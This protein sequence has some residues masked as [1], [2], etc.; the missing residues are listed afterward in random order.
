MSCSRGKIMAIRIGNVCIEGVNEEDDLKKH[1]IY[2]MGT[3]LDEVITKKQS[4][5]YEF[6]VIDGSK[7]CLFIKAIQC[8]FNDKWPEDP[9]ELKKII[10]E[11]ITSNRF[12]ER[13]CIDTTFSWMSRVI[14]RLP[15]R[16]III[17]DKE[18]TKKEISKVNKPPGWDSPKNN[19]QKW[20]KRRVSWID[21]NNIIVQSVDDF[22]EVLMEMWIKNLMLSKIEVESFKRYLEDI[23]SK[24]QD[25][26]AREISIGKYIGESNL[27]I[28]SIYKEIRYKKKQGTVSNFLEKQLGEMK[29][30]AKTKK[31]QT[32]LY[33]SH[34]KGKVEPLKTDIYRAKYGG[35]NY[36]YGET[37]SRNSLHIPIIVGSNKYRLAENA[38]Y[39]ILIVD[40]RVFK[41]YENSDI[42]SRFYVSGIDVVEQDY[43]EKIVIKLEKIE[44]GNYDIIIIHQ[45]ILDKMKDKLKCGFEHFV[46]TLKLYI[47]P[48]VFITSGRGAPENI[49]QNTKFINFSSIESNMMTSFHQKVIL[50]NILMKSLS[51][52]V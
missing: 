20:I 7:E 22:E 42:R 6:L 4:L 1:G 9:D 35:K 12:D 13:K 48:F 32:I 49:P 52:G 24:I 36:Y 5:D 3:N 27:K 40:E 17:G 10:K 46:N 39:R 25:L 16:V 26:I 14:E 8:L 29:R 19:I 23:N 38:L 34:D 41:Y 15:G 18:D 51:V 43:L 11:E 21:I 45:G 28:P 44:P 50:T 47:A 31:Y 30:A 37:L 33:L 2:Y